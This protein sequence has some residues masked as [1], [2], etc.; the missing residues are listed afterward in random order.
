MCGIKVIQMWFY[1]VEWMEKGEFQVVFIV[2][3]LDYV[4]EQL[5]G[6]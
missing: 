1:L 6:D 5:F 4:I 3:G 2:I